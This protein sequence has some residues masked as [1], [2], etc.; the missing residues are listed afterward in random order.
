MISSD[1]DE[2]LARFERLERVIGLLSKV[3]MGRARATL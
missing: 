3:G 1:Y 2:A